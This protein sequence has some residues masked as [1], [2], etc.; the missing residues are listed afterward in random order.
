MRTIHDSHN[1]STSL[2]DLLRQQVTENR[3]VALLE[4]PVPNGSNMVCRISCQ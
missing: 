3:N 1:A 4:P 2:H